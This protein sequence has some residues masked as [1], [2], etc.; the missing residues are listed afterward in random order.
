MTISDWLMISAV[1]T[2]PILA[3][4]VQKFIESWREAKQRKIYIFKTL[5]ATRGTTLSPRH[6]EALNIIDVPIGLAPKIFL[7]TA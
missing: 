3:V 5:M 2:G 7:K 1:L 4:Q 6:V